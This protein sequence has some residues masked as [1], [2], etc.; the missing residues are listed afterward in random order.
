M[1]LKIAVTTGIIYVMNVKEVMEVAEGMEISEGTKAKVMN[2]LRGCKPT[3][4]VG[5]DVVDL[6]LKVIDTDF[7]PNKVVE[8]ADTIVKF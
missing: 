3:D 1:L 4:E 6:I 7:D 5:D 2:M 8:D